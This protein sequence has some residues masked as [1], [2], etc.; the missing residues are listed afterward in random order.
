M[1]AQ[2]L[3]KVLNRIARCTPS[4]E[5]VKAHWPLGRRRLASAA[6]IASLSVSLENRGVGRGVFEAMAR[7]EEKR[8]KLFNLDDLKEFGGDFG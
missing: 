3:P 2:A 1:K 5:E 7:A 8:K 4:P 6:D